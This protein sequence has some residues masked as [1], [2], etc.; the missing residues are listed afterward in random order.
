MARAL[1]IASGVGVHV[2]IL[3]SGWPGTQ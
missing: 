1:A 3:L 2:L